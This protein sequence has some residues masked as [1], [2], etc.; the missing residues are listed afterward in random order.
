V[1]VEPAQACLVAGSSGKKVKA[2]GES[3]SVIG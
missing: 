3:K 1:K 2:S